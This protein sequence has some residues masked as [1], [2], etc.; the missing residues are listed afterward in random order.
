MAKELSSTYKLRLSNIYINI[1][2]LECLVCSAEFKVL[3][4]SKFPLSGFKDIRKR[5]F[6]FVASVQLLR[7]KIALFEKLLIRNMVKININF[8]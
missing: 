5:K 7:K 3:E 6:E 2:N 4:Y 8:L 1:I